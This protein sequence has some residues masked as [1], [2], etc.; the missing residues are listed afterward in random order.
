M[1]K[2]TKFLYALIMVL[3]FT[4]ATALGQ[5]ANGTYL[6]IIINPDQYP[7][8][9]SWAVL[10]ENLDTVVSGGPYTNIVDYSPQVTQLCV[11]NGDYTFE[12]Y[13]SFGDGVAG[14][15]WG[16]QDGSYYIVHCGDTIVDI[17]DADFGFSAFHGF[18]LDDCAPPP[19]IYGCMN[20]NF[21]EFLPVATVDTGMCLTPRVY[22][23]T[24]SLAY[25][26]VDS[27][28]TD[29]LT[30]SC[31][32]TLELTDLAGNGWAGSYLQVFQGN[33]FLGIFTL[34]NGFDT[35]FTFELSISEP[36]GI[37]FN[38]TQQSDFTAVQCG[39]SLYSDEHVAMYEPGGF[40]NP[41]A[42]FQTNYGL[43]Y[44]GDNC[45][46]KT[47]GCTD[48]LAVNYND[49]VNTDDGTCYYNPGCTNPLYLEY[50]SSYDYDDGSC[51]TVVVYGCMDSTAL[52]YDSL[53]NVELLN[54]CI[55]IVEGCMNPLAF[56]YNPN[57]NVDDTCIAV[58][59]G[60]TNP[61]ALNYD[62]AANTDDN[63]CVFA[64]LGCTDVDALNYNPLANTDDGS[65]V[66]V[67]FGCTDPSMFNYDISANT[68][69][70]S[71]IPFTYGCTDSTQF[72]Y[73]PLANTDNGSCIPYVYGCTESVALNYNPLANTNDGSCIYP[74]PG[75]TD[76]TALNYEP[77]ANVDDGSCIAVVLGC[78]DAA[79]FNYNL[80]ANVDDGSCIPV[81]FG[82]IDNTMFNYNPNANT[83]NGSCIPFIYGCTDTTAINYNAMAN[84]T[85]DSSW[86]IYPL[87]GCTDATAINYNASAN[88]EDSTCYYSAGCN[89]GDIYYVPNECFEWVIDIDP[90]CCDNTW[91]A[92]CGTLYAYCVDGWSGPTDIAMFE[93][94]EL[95]PYPNP[96]TGVVNFTSEVDVK[97]YNTLGEFII[98]DRVNTIKLSKGIYL[99]K[100][101][102]DKLN[103]TTKLI[104]Q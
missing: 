9:T 53:A 94:L 73:N 102:K 19:P 93:R 14:S 54:S 37:K 32:H 77:A 89:S 7:E 103:V 67:V 2:F 12:I 79:S 1:N 88:M 10:D 26:Y 81:I 65:C 64:I 70:G 71:C 40:A 72:N 101:S 45:I 78:T 80:S 75:C 3:V 35:T 38:I 55:A 74:V 87:P 39:Y 24:D 6:D 28:N 57:A 23:C 104:I 42:P 95:L 48:S 8:E 92:T 33:N 43:P 18:T 86:C 17:D 97:V 90:Y 11:P 76:S 58:V 61:T 82:C 59:E 84:Y 29:I 52:N 4:A 36:V 31:T 56:N 83:D 96:S 41:L 22:G 100:I 46:E 68:D 49:T 66:Q 91:D 47:Y 99:I 27:A 44:C 21:V 51:A 20:P 63:S 30:D 85:P 60:C 25:N 62:V 13:D 5:C 98:E 50:D 34:D 16:G 15:L 69:N